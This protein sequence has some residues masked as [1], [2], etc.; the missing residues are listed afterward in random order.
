MLMWERAAKKL[1]VQR[2]EKRFFLPTRRVLVDDRVFT[3]KCQSTDVASLVVGLQLPVT[4][5][6]HK[7]A[8]SRSCIRGSLVHESG[9]PCNT[10]PYNV[11]FEELRSIRT[12]RSIQYNYDIALRANSGAI[13]VQ[14]TNIHNVLRTMDGMLSG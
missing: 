11:F 8:N 13:S 5:Q 10:V 1:Q 9:P 3:I 4:I 7:D 14:W 2:R 6:L 12:D